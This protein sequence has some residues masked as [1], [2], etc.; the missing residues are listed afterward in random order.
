METVVTA[1]AVLSEIPARRHIVVLGEI[2]ESPPPMRRAYQRIGAKA[3]EICDQPILVGS[4]SLLKNYAS[5]IRTV[6]R[7]NPKIVRSC[8]AIATVLENLEQIK[9]GDVVLI[10]GSAR[11]HLEQ[12]A[13]HL[14][15]QQV[16][17]SL[18]QCYAKMIYERCS[19]LKL[20]WQ[21][22]TPNA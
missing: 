10:K 16:G 6:E 5:G 21:S 17:C 9:S 22:P 20:D 8:N 14:A 4:K 11:Q 7:G 3:A 13:L 19:M 2:S 12:I 15:G 1:L 18:P